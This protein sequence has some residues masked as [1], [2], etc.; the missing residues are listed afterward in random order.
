MSGTGLLRTAQ[1]LDP[2]LMAESLGVR[3]DGWQQSLVRSTSGRVLV[4]CSRQA[5]KTLAAALVALHL[6]AFRPRSLVLAVSPAQRQ[7]AELVRRV[8]AYYYL[9]ADP[10]PLVAVG[11]THLEMAN[12][13]R[14]LSLPG[15]EGTIRGFAAVDLLLLDE[16][17]RVSDSLYNSV[18]PML[19][20][21]R[22]RLIALSTP[23]G[24]RGWFHA[25]WVSGE[26]WER[27]EVK[28]H[29]CPRFSAEFLKREAAE[30]GPRWFRQEYQ[31]SFEDDT[32]CPFDMDAV[33]RAFDPK[34]QPLFPAES[35]RPAWM[36]CLTPDVT[37]LLEEGSG[38]D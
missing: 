5:G 21:S 20:T 25:A 24:K 2:V 33:R 13:S 3:L 30:M 22:G 26:P 38:D 19:A 36:S 12:G 34:V 4:L 8:K 32:G 23:A 35:G 14:I 7:S 37:A 28:G 10:P 31:C 27:V 15:S 29:E 6:L 18:R 17:S 1:H 9:L 11:V 16:A